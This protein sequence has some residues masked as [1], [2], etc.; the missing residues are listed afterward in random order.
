MRIRKVV[1]CMLLILGLICS[2]T[3]CFSNGNVKVDKDGNVIIKDKDNDGNEVVLGEKKW[4]KSKMHGL[5]A[6][7]AKVETSITSD[8]GTVYGFSEMKE[9]DAKK[10]IQKIKDAGFT[11][12]SAT[13]EDYIYS[14]TNK[15]G[16]TISFMY[17]KETGSGTVVS[18]KGEKPS[19][20]DN[21]AI[22]IFGGSDKKW[23]SEEMGGLPDPGVNVTQYWTNEGDTN[24]SL[25]VIPSYVDYVEEIKACGFTIDIQETQFDDSYVYIALNDNG[26]RIVFSVSS[27][28]SSITFEKNDEI[29]NDSSEIS[30]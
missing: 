8:E 1:F 24:Y 14:A 3:G 23:D 7:K 18:G 25:E 20:D 30:Y 9:K 22:A 6:P 12:N 26:D 29:T 16:L 5:E 2:L 4:E 15:D 27:D 11:Y 28:M 10:Y 21:G 17:D 19:E 13:F